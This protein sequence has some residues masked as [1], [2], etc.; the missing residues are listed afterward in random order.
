MSLGTFETVDIRNLDLTAVDFKRPARRAYVE[1]PFQG[2][3]RGPDTRDPERV[4]RDPE[5]VARD[6]ERVALRTAYAQQSAVGGGATDD[7][8]ALLDRVIA[9]MGGLD[10]LRGVKTIIATQQIT[11]TG[12]SDTAEGA[13]TSYIEYPN[14]FRVESNSFY[15][16][17][18]SGYDGTTAWSR[19]PRGARDAPGDVTREAQSNLDRDVI[20]V[21]LAGRDGTLTVRRLPGGALEFS[22]RGP[23][24]IEL[25]I[26]PVTFRVTKEAFAAGLGGQALVEETFSDYRSVAGVQMPFLAE[27]R[28]GPLAIRRRVTQLRVNEPIDPALFTRSGS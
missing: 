12:A 9:A 22:G 1:R 4:T 21:L 5:R 24:P 17:M 18:I 8:K 28:I 27:R 2:R 6:P 25:S 11:N 3:G 26:D 7:A 15:G 20:R 19:D 14:H 13:S 16:L 23:G 10:A